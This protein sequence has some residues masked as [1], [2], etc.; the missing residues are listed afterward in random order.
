MAF[1][2]ICFI[3]QQQFET[4]V[5]GVK[6]AKGEMVFNKVV[7]ANDLAA[8]ADCLNEYHENKYV[9]LKTY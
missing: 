2:K 4:G 1:E 7:N 8:H 3:C 5:T 9:Q 6:I